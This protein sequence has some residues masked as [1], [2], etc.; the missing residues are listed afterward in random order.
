MPEFWA[1]AIALKPGAFSDPVKTKVGYHI[2]QLIEKRE[3]TIKSLPEVQGQIRE[4][5]QAEK[6]KKILDRITQKARDQNKVQV[7]KELLSRISVT[8]R[9]KEHR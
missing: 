4:R 1:A 8:K 2:I 6:E 3:A 5:L 7:N 9:G